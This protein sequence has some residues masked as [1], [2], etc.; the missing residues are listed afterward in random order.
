MPSRRRDRRGSRRWHARGRGCRAC[1]A[2]AAASEARQIGHIRVELVRQALRG[3]KQVAAGQAEAVDVGH[4]PG[5]GGRVR[6]L[7]VEDVDAIDRRPLLGQRRRRLARRARTRCF[8]DSGLIDIADPPCLGQ[9]P[10]SR[11]GPQYRRRRAG[12]RSPRS[13]R[14]RARCAAAPTSRPVRALEGMTGIVPPP[15]PLAAAPAGGASGGGARP[16]RDR[17]LRHPHECP[18]ARTSSDVRAL[19]GMT[20]IEPAPSVWKTKALPLS[21]IPAAASRGIRQSM[22]CPRGP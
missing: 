16:K 4:D 3:R 20:G 13:G 12:G 9:S 10:A 17:F 5:V 15:T 1:P 22:A 2:L 14:A 18:A 6:R 21:Y 8:A 19:E 7:A 11:S